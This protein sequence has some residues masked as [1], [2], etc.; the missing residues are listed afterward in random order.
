[1]LSSFD[2]INEHFFW[3]VKVCYLKQIP[4]LLYFIKH[5]DQNSLKFGYLI[6]CEDEKSLHSRQRASCGLVISLR[7]LRNTALNLEGIKLDLTL[8]FRLTRITDPHSILVDCIVQS[9]FAIRTSRGATIES[10]E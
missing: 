7:I 8:R 5:V 4:Q 2:S 6:K 1:M 9:L 10:C 3:L